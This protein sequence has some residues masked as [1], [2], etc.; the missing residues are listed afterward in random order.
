MALEVKELD[1]ITLYE[2]AP[3]NPKDDTTYF[4]LHG[5]GTSLDFWV[6]VAPLLAKDNR[7]IAIDIPG[8]GRSSSPKDGLIL[9]ST[10]RQISALT[11]SLHVSNGV[12]VAHSLGAFAALRLAALEPTRFQRLILVDGTLGRALEF[13]K[14]PESIFTQPALGL[15]VSMQFLGGILPLKKHLANIVGH[16]SLLR[17]LTLR[18]WVDDPGHLDP[19]IVAAAL[20]NNGGLGVVRSLTA[21]RHID[22]ED[23][24]RGITQPVDL[25]WGERD[26]LINAADIEYVAG[27]VNVDRR[28]AIPKCGHWPMIEFPSVLA[29][30]ISSWGEASAASDEGGGL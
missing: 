16:S 28:L 6:A 2:A 8:F 4:L 20:S 5:I 23:L 29:R 14:H 24:L 3:P 30:F 9:E 25:I 1:H 26:N 18:P 27:L 17:S 15:S 7:T 12:L 13:V 11:Q 21:A 22:Y 19:N 10:A